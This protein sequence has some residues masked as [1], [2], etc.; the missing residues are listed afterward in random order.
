MYKFDFLIIC[1]IFNPSSWLDILLLLLRSG[2]DIPLGL[3]PLL[4]AIFTVEGVF[5]FTSFVHRSNVV[6]QFPGLGAIPA[7]IPE[8]PFTLLQKDGV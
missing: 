1:F 2:H 8:L 5:I 7:V 6:F 3:L 4:S